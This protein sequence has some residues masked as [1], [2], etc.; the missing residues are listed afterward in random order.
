MKKFLLLSVFVAFLSGCSKSAPSEPEVVYP[1]AREMYVQFTVKSNDDTL[2]AFEQGKYYSWDIQGVVV[3]FDGEECHGTDVSQ[4][5]RRRLQ[6]TQ[7][8]EGDLI[9]RYG[10]FLCSDELLAEPLKIHFPDGTQERIFISS[11]YRIEDYVAQEVATC[12]LSGGIVQPLE[13][14]LVF[15]RT[16]EDFTLTHDPEYLSTDYSEDGK[17]E[18]LQRAQQG[19]GIDIVIMGDAFSDRL[20]KKGAY[21]NAMVSA[22]ENFFI[23]EP[24]KSHRDLFNVYMVTCVSANEVI[25]PQGKT[26]L[27]CTRGDGT[28]VEGDVNTIWNYMFRIPEFLSDF[29]RANETMILGVVNRIDW[30]GTCYMWGA[31]SPV[32]GE[33]LEGDHGPGFSITYSMYESE[34]LNSIAY[35]VIHEAEGHGFA[36]LADEYWY[37]HDV[38][39]QSEKDYVTSAHLSGY[40]LNVDSSGKIETSPWARFAADSR[41]AS[42]GIGYYE[43]GNYVEKGIWRDSRTSLMQYVDP[44]F[45]VMSRKAAYYRINRLA[46]GKSWQFD[47]DKYVEFDLSHL[48]YYPASVRQRLSHRAPVRIARESKYAVLGKPLRLK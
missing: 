38:A 19:R 29:S 47:Y 39:T 43:G 11:R 15:H 46:W 5:L 42:S 18:V 27:G 17:V 34:D 25:A 36:K 3:E 13:Q 37:G 30:A 45:S 12:T 21:R 10:P 23:M 8:M 4:I 28:L 16:L 44:Q 26:A 2:N 20:I 9:F 48:V 35:T 14:K 32:T 24:F 41:Y 7:D 1:Q 40:D 22:M 33:P 6:F 31:Y